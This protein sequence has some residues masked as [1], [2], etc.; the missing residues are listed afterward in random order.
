MFLRRRATQAEYF[1]SPA[2]TPAEIAHGHRQLALINRL[3]LFA[4]PFQRFLPAFLGSAD[5][6]TLTFL[7]LGAGDG[8]LGQQLSNW[9]AT[10]GWDWSFVSLDLNHTALSLNPR[11]VN[12]AASVTRL[13]F[14]NTSVDVVIASQMTH[15]LNGESH[16]RDHFREA[17]RV[18]RRAVFFNDLHRN[19]LLYGVIWMILRWPGFTPEFR[20]DGLLSA[21]RAFRVGEWRHFAAQ[22]GIHNPRIW[23]HWGA[24]VM[25]FAG[26]PPRSSAV[27]SDGAAPPPATSETISRCREPGESC[28]VPS[29]K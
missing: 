18:A 14:R 11:G 15:H 10:R 9:A 27:R 20:A 17:W 24:R 12:V 29:D 19:Y 1:D 13:P 4:E 25:L 2:L 5:C 23:L 21:R 6:R 8:S 22:A 28:S 26:K 3:F 16:V 7:D